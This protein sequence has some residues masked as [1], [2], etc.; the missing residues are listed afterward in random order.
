V[1]QLNQLAQVRRDIG[2]HGGQSAMRDRQNDRL[3]MIT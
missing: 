2:G 3:F 1:L